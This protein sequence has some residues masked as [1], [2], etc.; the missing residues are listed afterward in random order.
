MDRPFGFVWLLVPA[1]TIALLAGCGNG[2]TG[3]AEGDRSLV[4]EDEEGEAV[5]R[6][7]GEDFSIEGPERRTSFTAGDTLGEDFPPELIYPRGTLTQ[8]ATVEEEGRPQFLVFWETDDD[9]GTILDFYEA[10]F[11]TLGLLGERVR[12]VAEG[13]AT[14]EVGAG[15]YGATVVIVEESGQNGRT[16]VAVGYLLE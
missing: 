9:S 7:E 14:L 11:D 2:D 8:S 6:V 13:F 1:A 3:D 15:D 5:L 16:V 10:A 12:T 4:L